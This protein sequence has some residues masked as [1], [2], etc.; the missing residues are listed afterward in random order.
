MFFSLSTSLNNFNPLEQNS[1]QCLL[2]GA[3]G[4]K[5]IAFLVLQMVNVAT[6]VH[7]KKMARESSVRCLWD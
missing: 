1:P 4:L 5:I 2:L 6:K 3:N 7:A